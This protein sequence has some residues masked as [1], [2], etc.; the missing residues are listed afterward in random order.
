M[1]NVQVVAIVNGAILTGLFFFLPE[2]QYPRRSKAQAPSLASSSSVE[3]SDQL[4]QKDETSVEEGIPPT[5][6]PK[7]SYLRQLNPWSGIHPDGDKASFLSLFIRSWPL[8]FYPAVAY[9]TLTFGLAVSGLLTVVNTAASVFQSPP[10]NMSPGIQSLIFV[11]MIIGGALGAIYGGVGT[12]LYA[13]YC[14]RKNNGVY[15]PE[16]RLVLLIG[17]L[18]IGPAGLL[19]FLLLSSKRTNFVGMPGVVRTWTHGSLRGLD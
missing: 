5:I 17:P 15:E 3:R 14:S 7:K 8:I 12:D 2:T 10:Y 4:H 19:M 9:S 6:P 11:S 16:N 1:A 18:L 13:K